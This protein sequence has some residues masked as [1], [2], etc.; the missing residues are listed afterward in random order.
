VVVDDRSAPEA[1]VERIRSAGA[2]RRAAAVDTGFSMS[3]ARANTKVFVHGKWRPLQAL[4]FVTNSRRRNVGQVRYCESK[5]CR[6]WVSLSRVKD[7][8]GN[9]EVWHLVSNRRSRAR[10]VAGEYVRR[11]GCEQGFRDAKWLLGFA[12]ARI[13]DIQTWSRFFA[14]FAIALLGLGK[15]AIIQLLRRVASHRHGCWEVSLVN[16]IRLLPKT[17]STLW[18]W[19]RQETILGLEAALPN[20]S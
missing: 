14:L 5:P 2:E 7:Q 19:L 16:A 17:G 12:E 6:A 13:T 20:V 15:H 4:R 1:A 18:Q 11:F 9:W 3:F 8:N 10:Q